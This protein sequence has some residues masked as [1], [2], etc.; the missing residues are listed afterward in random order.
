MTD[1]HSDVVVDHG[2][3]KKALVRPQSDVRPTLG[4][5]RGVDGLSEERDRAG[6]QEPN[7]GSYVVGAAERIRVRH[8]FARGS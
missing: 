5:H 6:I 2:R 8:A 4:R 3:S 1:D 7:A